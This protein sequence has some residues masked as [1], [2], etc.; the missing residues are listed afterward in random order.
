M[1]VKE[2]SI[3]DLE[4]MELV[5]YF[6]YHNNNEIKNY[7]IL[8]NSELKTTGTN[9]NG[10]YLIITNIYHITSKLGLYYLSTTNEKENIIKLFKSNINKYV[11]E[12]ILEA[13]PDMK[14][15]FNLNY[16]EFILNIPMIFDFEDYISNIR[17]NI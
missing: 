2:I 11:Y 13:H 1:F 4:T 10:N 12:N 14:I 8:N 3:F 5:K 17:K 9:I 15:I 6:L 7:I 16:D